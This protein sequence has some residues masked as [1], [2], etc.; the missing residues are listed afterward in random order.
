MIAD[1]PRSDEAR[2]RALYRRRPKKKA[3]LSGGG[4]CGTYRRVSSDETRPS[5]VL[6]VEAADAMPQNSG[7]GG[8]LAALPWFERE[9]LLAGR[10]GA[11]RAAPPAAAAPVS[12]D[13]PPGLAAATAAAEAAEAEEAPSAKR[14][15]SD[16]D[17]DA[18]PAK[19]V[20]VDVDL[21]LDPKKLKR[22]KVEELRAALEG[23]DVIRRAPSRDV[24]ERPSRRGGPGRPSPWR[25]RPSPRR[26]TRRRRRRPSRP[27]CGRDI[28]S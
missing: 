9:A 15:L 16:D 7:G 5:S 25:W 6:R 4:Y 14:P 24:G 22:L 23:L 27:R 19:K 3:P 13:V 20:R 1:R 12:E 17:G 2:R 21:A 18:A 11:A 28:G 26:P 8:A 10:A